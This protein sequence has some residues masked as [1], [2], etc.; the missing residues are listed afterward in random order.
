[1]DG[2]TNDDYDEILIEFK[3][4]KKKKKKRMKKEKKKK[5]LIG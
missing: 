2:F 5:W 1:M 4:K 3:K